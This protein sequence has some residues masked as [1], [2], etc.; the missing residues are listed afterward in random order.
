MVKRIGITGGIGS[1]KS[2]VLSLLRSLGYCTADADGLVAQVVVNPS[3]RQRISALL[4]KEAYLSDGAYNRS[5]VRECVFAS[6]QL[7]IQLQSI[8]HPEVDLEFSRLTSQL[9]LVSKCAWFFY[10]ASLI[11]ESGREKVFDELVLVTAPEHIRIE[12]VKARSSLS[13]VKVQEILAAQASDEE[14][15]KFATYEIAN[16]IDCADSFLVLRKE[17]LQMIS[18]LSEKFSVP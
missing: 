11:V 7:R 16:T 9:A 10:E 4:G 1:G 14:K 17:V 13:D 8:I 6:P 2:S 12:R 5:F 15:R 3:V 18:H